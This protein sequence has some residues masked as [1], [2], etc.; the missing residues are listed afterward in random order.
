MPR[1]RYSRWLEKSDQ[2]HLT[3]D[4]GAV[5]EGFLR[6]HATTTR[7]LSR[8]LERAEGLSLKTISGHDP[9]STTPV[10]RL[11]PM[12]IAATAF[13]LPIP[14]GWSRLRGR[15][16]AAPNAEPSPQ[17]PKTPERTRIPR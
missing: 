13:V 9:P 2:L 8:E 3:D 14:R 1:Q 15:A 16:I 10:R 11:R 7:A 12:S 4:E 6:A 5:W 17:R